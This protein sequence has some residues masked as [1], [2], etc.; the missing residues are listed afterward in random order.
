MFYSSQNVGS[1]LKILAPFYC[2]Q[3]RNS[4]NALYQFSCMCTSTYQSVCAE[5]NPQCFK[6]SI[7][8]KK[9]KPCGNWNIP[10]PRKLIYFNFCNYGYQYIHQLKQ[11]W[12]FWNFSIKAILF[13]LCALCLCWWIKT[14]GEH[15][16][17]KGLN[18]IQ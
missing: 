4:F 8:L 3:T 7:K 15:C 18:F 2:P 11:Q 1:A 10:P 17:P 14:F 12:K 9:K 13:F 6:A 16:G 5:T